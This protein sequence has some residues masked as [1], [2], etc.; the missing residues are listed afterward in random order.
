MKT[1]LA[2]AL[3]A[4]VLTGGVLVASEEAF[5]GAGG[6]GPRKFGSY[7]ELKKYL[8]E[9]DER[10]S[11]PSRLDFGFGRLGGLGS[12]SA[13]PTMVAVSEAASSSFQSTRSSFPAT[14]ADYST[15]N[16][17]VEGVDE[18]DIVKTDG[19]YLYVVSHG[20]VLILS[21]HPPESA[22]LLSRIEPEGSVEELFIRGDRL[23]VLGRKYAD[24]PPPMLPIL[25]MVVPGFPNPPPEMVVEPAGYGTSRAYV[26]IYDVSR[27]EA[28][29]LLQAVAA[30]GDY[31][32]ARLIGSHVY[33]VVNDPVRWFAGEVVMPR[34][35]V[36]GSTSTVE[37]P[38]VGHFNATEYSYRF[39][40]VLSVDLSG[41]REPGREVFLTGETQT[42][43][44]S[45]DHIYVAHTES[46]PYLREESRRIRTAPPAEETV[47]HKIAIR[48]GEIRYVAS[49]TVPGHLLNQFSLDQHNGTL[50]VAT[51]TGGVWSGG[52]ANHIYT[53]D[54][55]LNII[56]RLENLAPGERIYSARFLGDRAYLVTF[57]KVDPLFVIDLADPRAPRV[58]GELKIPGYSDYLHPYDENHL[59]GIG[60]ETIESETGDF[61]WY[62]GLKLA[63]FDVS[64]VSSPKERAK[65]VVGDRGTDSEA[66]RD[67]KAF[68]F[69]RERSLL[70]LPVDLALIEGHRF[71]ED[72]AFP[73]YGRPVFQGAYVWSLTPE[74]GFE[75]RGRITHHDADGPDY[76]LRYGS[77]LTIRRSLYIG[78]TLYTV[79]EGVVKMNSLDTLEEVGK[80]RLD[81]LSG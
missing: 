9:S 51:T 32:D 36:D 29:T 79:S 37:A 22:R 74:R 8:K 12:P 50:R 68:L 76:G 46:A 52:S 17:Q 54:E 62:Q 69:S 47:I 38:E 33:V 53:L 63:L 31:F 66:L 10:V 2:F 14:S 55:G 67:H 72:R 48:D 5:E 44:V 71:A 60:K 34:V 25:P 21:A 15:T 28:P 40:T 56:G 43:Y 77:D 70:V 7:E 35:T 49:G 3:A 65:V 59:I 64:N 20:R 18:P 30:D 23:V 16:I 27:R 26:K 45:T 81:S 13:A 73:A 58:L 75:F 78:E 6:D 57:K 61:A 39:T 80:V 42:L 11:G 4:L 24:A 1:L 41:V 19:T